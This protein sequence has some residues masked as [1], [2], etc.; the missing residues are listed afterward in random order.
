MLRMMSY[1]M[2]YLFGQLESS[3]PALY[4]PNFLCT[5]GLLTGVVV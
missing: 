4:P 3:V 5:L 1:G 2:E